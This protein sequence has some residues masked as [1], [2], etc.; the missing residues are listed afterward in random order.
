MADYLAA[1]DRRF[2]AEREAALDELARVMEFTRQ[3]K[4][5]V[6]R[7][8]AYATATAVTEPVSL[9][10]V[11]ED[12]LACLTGESGGIAIVHDFEPLP[13]V[14]IDKNRVMQILVNL[15]HNARQ[16]L[17]QQGGVDQTLTVR[18]R[19][20][21]ERRIVLEVSDNGVGIATDIMPNLFR[22]G[23]TTKRDGHGFG[24]HASANMA[25]EMGGSL[26][27]RSD[28][29]GQ[30]ASFTLEL[31]FKPL[32]EETLTK[33]ENCNADESEEPARHSA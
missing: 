1:L 31:P 23:F 25:T 30:G 21:D 14:I 5:T 16:A 17:A 24:L 15:I 10:E 27:C 2:G 28:G 13:R 8:Q 26:N 11:F 9:P 3:I 6:A 29:S 18:I 4:N 22:H 7:Q 20:P 19:R 32:S 33:A 12:A